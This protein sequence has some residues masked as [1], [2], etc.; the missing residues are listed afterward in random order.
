MLR[1]LLFSLA[2]LATSVVHASD[3]PRGK[4]PRQVVPTSYA[5]DLRMDARADRYSGAVAIELEVKEATD[6]FFIHARGS[7]LKD[8]Q[9]MLDA[10]HTAGQGLPLSAAHAALMRAAVA[11]GDGDLDNA[12]IVQQIRR[13]VPP[14]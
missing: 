7:T 1:T 4:L 11:A 13:E 3:V 6:H 2:I 12:A 10:A 9:L 8:V 5:V 14:A